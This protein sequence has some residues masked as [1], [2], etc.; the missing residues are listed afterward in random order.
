MLRFVLGAF[1]MIGALVFLGCPV[2]MMLRIAGGDLN[3]ITALVG[4]IVG[5]LVGIFFLKRGFNLGRTARVHSLAGWMLPVLMVG[6]LLLAIFQPGFIFNS[7]SGPGAVFA[8]LGIAIVVGLVVGVDL[9]RL[10][11]AVAHPLLKRAQRD[12]GR[13]HPSAE[14]MAKVVETNGAYAR[15]VERVL[16][17]PHELRMVEDLAGL[18]VAEHEVVISS[19]RRTLVVQFELRADA[20]SHRH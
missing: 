3:G 15:G 18:R 12:A 8:P 5:I 7:E 17:A 2:R 20:I 19:V 14:G 9:G 4:L 16:E 11:V 10:D 6:L 13:R 1:V